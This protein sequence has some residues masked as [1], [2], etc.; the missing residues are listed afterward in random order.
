MDIQKIWLTDSARH[1]ARASSMKLRTLALLLIGA[2]VFPVTA[3]I[4]YSCDFEDAAARSRW[5]LNRTSKQSVYD[6][7]AN[8]WY[9]GEPGNG[10]PGGHY[11]LYV[12]DDN[13]SSAHYSNRGCWVAAY[14]TLSLAY[15]S[16]GN[17]TL[18]FDYCAMG[19]ISSGFDGMYVLWIP[20]LKENG[21]SMKVMSMANN[22][23]QIPPVYAEYVL[24]TG[25]TADHLSGASSWQQCVLTI[26]GRMCDGTPHY[27]VF[28]WANGNSA[29][30][31]PGAKIDNIQISDDV[32]CAAPTNM[33]MQIQ[34][35]N[36][37]LNWTG[38]ASEYE[39]SVYS[40][41]TET[42]I[43]TQ[44]V[45]GTTASFTD[46]PAGLTTFS[47][48]ALC[49]GGMYGLKAIVSRFIY[50]P[51]QMCVDFLNLDGAR[52]YVNNSPVSNT[53]VFN[54]FQQVSPVNF[55]PS[56]V[57]SRHTCH[58]DSYETDPR[59]GNMA[60]AVPEGESISV[61]LGNWSGESQAERIEY[62][63][64]GDTLNY[65]VLVFKY[66]PVLEDLSHESAENPRIHLDI[67]VNGQPLGQSYQLDINGDDILNNQTLTPE[68]VEQ[69]WHI[70]DNSVSQSYWNII[71]KEW[72][73][74]V[75][76]LSR[77]Q[78]HGQL[79]TVRVTSFDCAHGGHFGYVYFTIGCSDDTTFIP[80][81]ETRIE[82]MA[83]N[84]SHSKI[85]RDGQILILRG[86]KTYTLTGQE[87]K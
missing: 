18:T 33:I 37:H 9:I 14:D 76:D 52:C 55:G 20:V 60:N 5:V 80:G 47:V 58:T 83:G 79:L 34:A 10:T 8:K 46:I 51:E 84:T 7:L 45:T 19:N 29:A 75:F 24:P 65:P 69:G 22:S 86:G 82:N 85:L 6:Q 23:G 17:Y 77:S 81:E 12:S 71:W 50:Y 56:S 42:W 27:L 25:A 13:G 66:M 73:T 87:L 36:V 16:S 35:N 1:V 26:S 21:D 4:K 64:V 3:S 70:T 30:Q 40:E 74:A 32:P 15:R 59:T 63:F 43:E 61:R 67:L 49:D 44:T 11:G 53:M 62:D 48:R 68:A 54:D 78:F 72:S 39:V 57:N 28:V 2:F 38:T 31:Q 41:T